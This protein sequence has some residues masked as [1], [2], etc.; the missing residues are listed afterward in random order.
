MSN[1]ELKVIRQLCQQAMW[2]TKCPY[3]MTPEFIVV[4]NTANDASAVNEITY[5][6]RNAENTSFHYA[7]DDV[8][9]VQ[10]IEE[11]R[12]AFHAGDGSEGPGNRKGIA[13]EICYSKGGGERFTKA[14]EN[15][16]QFIAERLKYYGWGIDKVKKH[17]D[18]SNKYC[19]HRTLDLG[20]QRFLDK[21]Q[22]YMVKDGWV[23]D[24]IYGC[25]YYHSNGKML[26]N[27]DKWL[28]GKYYHFKEN[29]M[30]SA[31]E[32]VP[33]TDKMGKKQYFYVGWDGAMIIDAELEVMHDG[34][35]SFD[36]I[37]K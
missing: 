12:N 31:H 1:S 23:K 13:I 19:P 7:I 26:K 33:Y 17:Q 32:F 36:M 11:N 4:H 14:E 3:S 37:L 18:F 28:D 15:A 8:C 16:A 24:E 35:I 34:R 10:G 25:W 27:I 5:M 22:A 29:G 30:M 9:V 20:W 6:S 21:V 2:P